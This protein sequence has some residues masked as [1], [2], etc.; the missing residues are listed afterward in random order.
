VR[1]HPWT[2]ILLTL[3]A[4]CAGPAPEE[5]G[6][7]PL[8]SGAELTDA[9]WAEALLAHREEVR[10]QFLT[11]KTSPIAGSQRLTSE[12]ADRVDLVR[13]DR[14]FALAPSADPSAEI[15]LARNGKGWTVERLNEGVSGEAGDEPLAAGSPLDGPASFDV[16]DLHLSL[17]PGPETV[18]FIVYDPERPEKKAFDHLLYFDPDRSYAVTAELVRIP[19]PDQIETLTSRGLKKTFY[20]YA[21]LR[22][23]LD[24]QDLELT[25]LKSSLEG[26]ASK[27]FFIPSRDTTA[28]KET[29]GA[30][31]Y[32]DL[33]EPEADRFVL[34]FNRAYNPLCNYSP[35]F[36]CP[37]PPPEN[38]LNVP[39]RAGE[40]TYPH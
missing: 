3:L 9:A 35:A 2:L 1:A 38:R 37:I 31:R 5:T 20:R 23:R 39:I 6:S 21:T 22:F 14:T 7:L 17:Y 10:Q 32:L 33:E 16:D 4:G 25:A 24:G 26:E 19:E 29:Y 34:D 27:S 18:T 12:P 15:A 40:L 13:E 28:G 36:N 30:G 8:P 11:S